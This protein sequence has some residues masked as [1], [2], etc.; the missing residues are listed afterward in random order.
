MYRIMEILLT[1]FFWISL[2]LLTLLSIKLADIFGSNWFLLLVPVFFASLVYLF[3]HV[4][5]Y[6]YHIIYL[7]YRYRHGKGRSGE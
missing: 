4:S 3:I 6:S 2:L 7:I 1:V 5:D